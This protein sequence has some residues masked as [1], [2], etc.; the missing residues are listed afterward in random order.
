MT[1]LASDICQSGVSYPAA[2]EIARQMN[3]GAPSGGSASALV[4]SG[5]SPM[6]ATELARQINAG[7]FSADLL[8]RAMWPYHLSNIIKKRSGL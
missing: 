7:S 1:V 6:P 5:I 8:C 4:N 2:I 3:V